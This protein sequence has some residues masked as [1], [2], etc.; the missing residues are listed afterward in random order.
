[1]SK[2]FEQP[3]EN[4]YSGSNPSILRKFFAKAP[5]FF[6]KHGVNGG[7]Q[8]LFFSQRPY[9]LSP[10]CGRCVLH[11]RSSS[12]RPNGRHLHCAWRTKKRGAIRKGS[13][14]LPFR[15]TCCSSQPPLSSPF[16]PRRPTKWRTRRHKKRPRRE[17][18][19][20]MG[21][22]L[23]AGESRKKSF[24]AYKPSEAA[25][26]SAQRSPSMAAETIPPA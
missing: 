25:R 8:G 14:Q 16:P 6:L 10:S 17:S 24:C 20:L 12:R 21:G 1:M 7:K 23:A 26:A 9:F 18:T 22:V 11:G 4:L 5:S 19:P 3:D 15:T 2:P 13:G